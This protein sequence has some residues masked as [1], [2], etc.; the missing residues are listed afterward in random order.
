MESRARISIMWQAAGNKYVAE[1]I[2]N[3]RTFYTCIS[4]YNYDKIIL[5]LPQAYR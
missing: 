1:K 4:R 3:I 2:I 5:H